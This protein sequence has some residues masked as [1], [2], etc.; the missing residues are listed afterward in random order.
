[1]LHLF[2]PI[3][4]IEFWDVVIKLFA[5]Q[6]LGGIIGVERSYKNRPAGFRTHILVALGAAIASMTGIYIYIKAGLPADVTRI[7]AAV[8]SGL[9]FLGAGTIIVT[10][11]HTV[12]GLTTAAGLWTSGIIGLAVGAGFYEGAIITTA[13]VVFAEAALAGVTTRIK[14]DPEFRIAVLFKQK[15]ALDQVLRSCKN[16]RM[17]ITNLH[18]VSTVIE[19]EPGYRGFVSLRPRAKIDRETLYAQLKAIPGVLGLREVDMADER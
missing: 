8:V 13:L 5:A 12:K 17:T 7:G 6:L 4:G 9:G 18:V 10:K 15:T 1:M 11:N 3:R 16:N 14:R 19:N 2:D